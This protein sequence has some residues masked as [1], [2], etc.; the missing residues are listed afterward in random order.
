M[1]NIKKT[2]QII[3]LLLSLLLVFAV[4]NTNYVQAK[5]KTSKVQITERQKNLIKH[6][7]NNSIDIEHQW[8]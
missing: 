7:E 3:S 5:E 1:K 6:L 2:K 4:L 8:V